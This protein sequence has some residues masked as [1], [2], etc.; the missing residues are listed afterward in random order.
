MLWALA[1]LEN[2]SGLSEI[3]EVSHPT[4][5]IAAISVMDRGIAMCECGYYSPLATA[6]QTCRAYFL[7][8]CKYHHGLCEKKG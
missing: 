6:R 2:F 3:R 1:R 8:F 5:F 4:T 7:E